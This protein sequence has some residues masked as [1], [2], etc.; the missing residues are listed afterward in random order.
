MKWVE[1][2]YDLKHFYDY[3]NFYT[4]LEKHDDIIKTVCDEEEAQINKFTDYNIIRIYKYLCENPHY[5][6]IGAKTKF[7]PIYGHFLD[8]GNQFIYKRI[9]KYKQI[10]HENNKFFKCQKHELCT[11][12][13]G[14]W[15][16]FNHI[17]DAIKQSKV[18]QDK[19]FEDQ[20]E[21]FKDDYEND[22]NYCLITE[23]IKPTK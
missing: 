10:N 6:I 18:L 12:P 14:G 2:L 8:S 23:Y 13:L 9:Y 11:P 19:E 16:I 3:D 7:L 20:Q 5:I 17:G 15:Y 22:D 1:N 21:K 4:I